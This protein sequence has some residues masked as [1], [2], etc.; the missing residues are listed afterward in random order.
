[1]S[2]T[3]AQAARRRPIRK[4][5]FGK[6][7]SGRIAVSSRVL[8]ISAQYGIGVDEERSVRV[9]PEFEIETLPGQVVFVTG[10]SGGGKSTVLRQVAAQ[11]SVSLRLDKVLLNEGVPMVDLFGD[12]ADEA[13]R[14]LGYVGLGEA[15]LALRKL[16]EL[17]DGQQFRAH[18]A[19]LA[20]MIEVSTKSPGFLTVIADEFCSTLDR[21]TAQCVTRC[22][23]RMVRKRQLTTWIATAHSDL[24]CAVDPDILIDAELGFWRVSRKVG[25]K[26][27]TEILAT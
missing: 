16:G 3:V 10:A 26:W 4:W 11:A 18:L 5:K 22:F 21:L 12:S 1:M 13:M 7:Y 25:G 6:V 9:V 14:I 2:E 19:G 15:F 23:M 27:Q 24:I 17:S 8:E 20:A